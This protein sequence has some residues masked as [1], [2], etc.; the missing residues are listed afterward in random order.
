MHPDKSFTLKPPQMDQK[1]AWSVQERFGTIHA[2]VLNEKFREPRHHQLV[3]A[4]ATEEKPRQHP[5]RPSEDEARQRSAPCRQRRTIERRFAGAHHDHPL[6]GRELEVTDLARVKDLPR[7]VTA[8]FDHWDTW[9]REDAV[10]NNHEI[11]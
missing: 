5:M 2:M 4:D 3:G 10:A 8:A 1:P 9:Y 6:A 11:E 7:K